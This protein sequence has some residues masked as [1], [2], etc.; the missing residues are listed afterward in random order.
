[1]SRALVCLHKELNPDPTTG[2]NSPAISPQ[3]NHHRW[4]LNCCSTFIFAVAVW[5]L[6]L[7]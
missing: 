6:L 3:R 7:V 2:V 4:L 1:V 5:R